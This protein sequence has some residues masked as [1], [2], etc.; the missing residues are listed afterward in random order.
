M[1]TCAPRRHR[2]K[3]IHATPSGSS[4]QLGPYQFG[5]LLLS[6]VLLLG[7]S[8]ELVFQLHPEI[9]RLILYLDTAV[10]ALLLVDFCVRFRNAESKWAFLKWGWIDLIASI[11]AIE[12]FRFGRILRVLRVLRLL[13][14]YRSLRRLLHAFWDSR[15]SAGLT[16]VL[17]ITFLVIAFGSTG[18]LIAEM[19]HPA[20]NLRT[21][22]DA[23]WWSIVTTTTVGYGDYYPVTTAGRI[24]ATFLMITGIGL[25]GTLS[26]VAASLFL[27]E[28]K[29]EPASGERQEA[30]LA[31]LEAL[32]QELNQLRAGQLK[33]P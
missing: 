32:Q 27:L 21:A 19:N 25:F 20:A 7:L 3:F 9:Q 23:L 6:V 30:M 1:R 26:G 2:L 14:A 8:L 13:F 10:C 31:Q 4:E 29:R 17:V 22:N 5:L 15:T 16:G 28:R 12:I 24:I 18:I 33:R 11:P